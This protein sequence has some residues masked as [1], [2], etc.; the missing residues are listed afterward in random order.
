[1]PFVVYDHTVKLGGE[2]HPPGKP[3]QVEDTHVHVESGAVVY[4]EDSESQMN[5]SLLEVDAV[6]TPKRAS[7][8]KVK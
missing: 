5:K 4:V 1:M 8:K 2:F 3:I 7:R 6:Q